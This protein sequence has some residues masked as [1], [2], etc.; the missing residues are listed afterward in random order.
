MIALNNEIGE[1]RGVA[2][3][4]YDLGGHLN[5]AYLHCYDHRRM[6]MDERHVFIVHDILKAWP[7]QN[8]LE[9]GSFWGAS[10]TAF[11]EAINSGSEMVATI[12]E[13][14]HAESLANV[15]GNC[16]QPAQIRRTRDLSWDVLASLEHFDFVLVDA[17]HDLES[18]SREIKPLLVRRPLCIMAHDTNATVA[19]YP[20]CEGAA[21]LKK[22]ITEL[23]GYFGTPLY[24]GIEDCKERPGEETER[25]LFLATTEP[26]LF[27]AAKAVFEKWQ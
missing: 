9:L 15:V 3:R 24:Q 20:K 14:N 11:V 17:N 12:C 6:C 25:G 13:V 7:F 2:L 27:R 23:P 18:V 8:A 19:G 26:H 22:T 1:F 16:K 4:P 5:E 21:L 10:T